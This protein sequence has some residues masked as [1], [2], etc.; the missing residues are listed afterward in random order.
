MLQPRRLA[1]HRG[2]V[3][4]HMSR[5]IVDRDLWKAVS[6]RLTGAAPKRRG[7]L[8]PFIAELAKQLKEHDPEGWAKTTN[9]SSEPEGSRIANNASGA[10]PAADCDDD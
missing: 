10:E 1:P 7:E 9:A 3:E 4:D 6:A 2:E 8:D 5:A